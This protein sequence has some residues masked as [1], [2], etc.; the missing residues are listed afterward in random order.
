[1]NFDILV[2]KVKEAGDL[3]LE[4]SLAY[5]VT[6]KGDKDF[7]T[8]YDLAI[9]E[10][11]RKDLTNLFPHIPLMAEEGEFLEKRPKSLFIL[12]P[13][14]GTTNFI[15]DYKES[16]VSLGFVHEEKPI[17]GVVYNPFSKELYLGEKGKGASLNGKKIQVSSIDKIE[18]ALI[19]AET[20]PYEREKSVEHFRVLERVF[21]ESM[22]LRIGGSASLDI[23]YVAVGRTQGFL[24]RR[25]SPW[26]YAGPLCI[27]QEAG[28]IYSQWDGRAVSFFEK[29]DILAANNM[30]IWETLHGII[31]K[32]V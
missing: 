11:L 5:Q 25:L 28:G 23:C 12:D 32:E 20:S 29:S 26:D 15:H 7:V 14:D 21:K 4:S 8:S 10:R 9:E 18:D 13:L 1:M 2:N 6:K 19:G 17:F 24:T 30:K 31:K 22:D 3:M 16:C 27:L